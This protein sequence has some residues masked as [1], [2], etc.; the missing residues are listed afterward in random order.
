MTNDKLKMYYSV[1]QYVPDPIRREAINVGLVCHIPQK[2]Y[3][4][5]YHI[6]GEK[7]LKAF[8]DECNIN[9]VKMMYESLESVFNM[10]S[11]DVKEDI[12]NRFS[13]ISSKNFLQNRIK[14]YANM[15]RFFNVSS[16]YTSMESVEEDIDFLKKRYLY[17]D[18]Q[19]KDRLTDEK[20]N[21]FIKRQLKRNNLNT[22]IRP[23]K[24]KD[25][26][27]IPKPIFDFQSDNEFIKVMAMNYSRPQSLSN[28]FKVFIYDMS[29]VQDQLANKT[30]KIITDSDNN[31]FKDMTDDYT[32]EISKLNRNGQVK[33]EKVEN[34][35]SSLPKLYDQYKSSIENF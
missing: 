15:F 34:Y 3:S 9:F 14:Y 16:M 33:I 31:D 6:K 24:L 29:T 26:T 7:R 4:I 30:I 25:K 18:Y 12:D 13:D 28:K 20:L 22:K 32:G 11:K 23:A 2:E 35:V 19:P 10:C 1:C 27:F 21:S 8:D 17:Y 5:F